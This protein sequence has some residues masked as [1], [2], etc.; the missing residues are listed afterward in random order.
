ME[1][2]K[3]METIANSKRDEWKYDGF[4]HYVYLPNISISI[5]DETQSEMEFQSD[6]QKV[7]ANPKG[8]SKKFALKYNGG[9]VEYF[10]AVAVDSETAYIPYPDLPQVDSEDNENVE[11]NNNVRISRIKYGV[12]KIINIPFCHNYDSYQEHIESAHIEII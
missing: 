7:Y 10:W 9:L 6:W 5:D 8:Y 4:G 11:E 12:G 1:Y 2:Q 3:F